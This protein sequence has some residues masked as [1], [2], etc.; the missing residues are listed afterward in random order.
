[1]VVDPPAIV[2]E[3]EPRHGSRALIP[4]APRRRRVIPV[5][6][7]V[8]VDVDVDL[9]FDPDLDFLRPAPTGSRAPHPDP[10]TIVHDYRP[11]AAS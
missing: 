4:R 5:D 8:A 6:V 11:P 1:M 9:D 2:G 7:D 3:E 10:D